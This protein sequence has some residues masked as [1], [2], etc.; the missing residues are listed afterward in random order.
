MPDLAT[1]ATNHGSTKSSIQAMPVT[2]RNAPIQRQERSRIDS[3]SA[4]KTTNIRISG[5]LS[6]TPAAI[7]VHKIAGIIQPVSA[8]GARRVPR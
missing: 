6:S 7:A 4:V 3:V 5:P 2:G 1:M 8:C